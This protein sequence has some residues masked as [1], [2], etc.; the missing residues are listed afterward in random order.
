MQI[1]YSLLLDTTNIVN[2][3]C[4]HAI[5]YYLRFYKVF[6]KLLPTSLRIHRVSMVTF[7]KSMLFCLQSYSTE[8]QAE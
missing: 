5:T 1:N 4:Y 2:V 3:R 7:F 6:S 8:A